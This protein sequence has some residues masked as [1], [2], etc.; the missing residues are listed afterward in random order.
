MISWMSRD[1]TK[2]IIKWMFPKLGGVSPKMNGE[3]NGK[4]LIKMDDLEGKPT[5]LETPIW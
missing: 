3:N 2:T 1:W 4:T 5:I